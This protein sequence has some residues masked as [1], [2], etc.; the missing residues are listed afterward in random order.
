MAHVFDPEVLRE[1]VDA[2]VG[3]PI[4]E[5]VET[6]IAA[7]QARYGEEITPDGEW[8]FSNAGGIMGTVKLLYASLTE[9]LLVFGTPHGSEGHSGRHRSDLWDIVMSGELSTYQEHEL[10]A[11]VFHPGDVAFL[12]RGS[13][14][15][16]RMGAEG[17]FMLEYCRGNIPMMLPFG[18]MDTLTSTLDLR[19]VLSTF[20]QHN[21]LVVSSLLRKWRR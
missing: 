9:Y 19:G 16:S 11:R 1:C 3:L 15:G 21:G 8:V 14:N 2:G 10:R 6:V 7:L 13:S 20:R 18:L 4:E 12:P 5:N 17:A